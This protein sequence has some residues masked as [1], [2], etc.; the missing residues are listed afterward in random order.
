MNN[1]NNMI[2]ATIQAAIN[3]DSQQQHVEGTTFWFRWV[4]RIVA[5]L[6][7]IGAMVC[8]VIGAI[9]IH[10]TCV[11]AGV[12]MIF[13][14]FAMIMF[15]VPIC[16]QFVQF[17]QPVAKFSERRP[18]WQK[19]MLYSLPPLLPLVLC[20]SVSIVLGFICLIVNGAVQ[21]MLA[22]GK[23]A[24]KEEMLARASGS[25]GAPVPDGPSVVTGI[26]TNDKG[27]AGFTFSQLHK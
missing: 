24:T 17:T 6:T 11:A 26:P 5:I 7:G 22:V 12:I 19:A 15:E 27:F 10:A 2:P 1:M 9:S 25:R 14:G 21:F 16:C 13:L 4:V 18:P 8:G 23:K 20:Q 3:A